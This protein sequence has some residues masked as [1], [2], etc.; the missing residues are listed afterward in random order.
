MNLDFQPLSL[1]RQAKY[2]E[3]L[4][5]TPQKASDY[6]FI[7][8]W[9]WQNEYGLEWTFAYG[10]LWIR[11]TKPHPLLWAPVGPWQDIDWLRVFTET[12]LQGSEFIRVPSELLK[13]WQDSA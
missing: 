4:Q 5:K 10:L 12:E 8:L 1:T 6:S 9:T 11:Q 3:L 2:R 13:L 7:N